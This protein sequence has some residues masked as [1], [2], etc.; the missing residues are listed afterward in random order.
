MHRIFEF[1]GV[2]N[3]DVCRPPGNAHVI[4][5]AMASTFNGEVRLDAAW[6][7]SLSRDEK[8]RI[9]QQAEPLFSRLGYRH[10]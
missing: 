10:E 6:E 2:E 1:M 5:N 7:T 9:A 4:G 8:E 3:H